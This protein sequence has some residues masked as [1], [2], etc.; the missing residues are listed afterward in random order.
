MLP[1]EERKEADC[2]AVNCDIKLV[3]TSRY[4]IFQIFSKMLYLFLQ[5]K[6]FMYVLLSLCGFEKKTSC[7]L[8]L[9][10][11]NILRACRLK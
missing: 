7:N 8:N 2:I 3:F 11:E 9:F 6:H 10:K 1:Y 4:V 5:I